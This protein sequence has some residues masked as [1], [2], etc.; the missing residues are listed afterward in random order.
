M[1]DIEFGEAPKLDIWGRWVDRLHKHGEDGEAIS[2]V[3]AGLPV[4]V[5]KPAIRSGKRR[6]H[7]ATRGDLLNFAF[8]IYRPTSDMR[9]FEYEGLTYLIRRARLPYTYE[10]VPEAR[11]ELAFMAA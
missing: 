11:G 6:L 1:S 9:E 3:L 2:A 10:F 4:Y 8:Y 5:M 7:R